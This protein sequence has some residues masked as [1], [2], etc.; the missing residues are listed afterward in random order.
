MDK[1]AIISDVHGNLEAL[2]TVLNDIENRGIKNIYCLGDII[3]KGVNTIECLEIIKE[4]CSVI[5]K[6]NCEDFF[7]SIKD[8]S[9]L[10]K[11]TKKRVEWNQSILSNEQ[12]EYLLNLPYCHEF[13]MSGSLIRM[14]HATPSKIDDYVSNLDSLRKK[15]SLFLPTE[16]TLSSEISDIVIYG[17]I[18]T[19]YMDKLCNKTII[20][21]GSVGNSID[22]IR[23]KSFDSNVLET[24]QAHYL[25]VEGKLN[26]KEYA[27][28]TF[29][30]IRI[31][32]NIDKELSCK[33]N[34]IE[35]NAYKV[36]LKEGK[37][38]DYDKLKK[39]FKKRHI[40]YNVKG[41]Y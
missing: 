18:H 8:V 26:S 11:L 10:D 38:R 21:V 31:P 28:L 36:E 6:G 16:N 30:F 15:K 35:K 32:Y 22:V 37:Y 12:K 39:L 23:D 9:C 4:K 13:Y 3:A 17:H 29:Q 7:C 20:N 41:R 1:I 24:T 34:N 25:I 14:F 2:T 40:K 5:L 19:Q 27:D 33:K